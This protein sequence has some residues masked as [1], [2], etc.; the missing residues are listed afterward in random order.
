MTRK[1]KIARLSFATRD[2][3]NRRLLNGEEGV[4]LVQWLNERSFVQAVLKEEFNGRPITGQNLSEWKQGGYQDWLRAEEGRDWVRSLV[5]ESGV[6][7]EEAG[8]YSVADWLAAPTAMALGRWLRTATAGSEN[9]PQQRQALLSVA[10]ELS[11]LRRGDHEEERIRLER[12]R[13]EAEQEET[14]ADKASSAAI[15]PFWKLMISRQIA[16]LYKDDIVKMGGKIP[17]DL[18]ALLAE[19]EKRKMAD[20]QLQGVQASSQVAPNPG[21][22]DQIQPNPTKKGGQ[23]G[24]EG[25][26]RS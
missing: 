2:Q 5:E 6:L 1:G 17:P 23:G 12:E 14:R 22:S 9:D 18:A 3:L 4:K 11:Q 21:K 20:D 24:Q 13:W 10:R 15:A 16:D 19:L 8:E 7:A 25:E 26:A